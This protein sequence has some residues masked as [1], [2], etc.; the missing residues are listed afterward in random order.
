M[1]LATIKSGLQ[2]N[3]NRMTMSPDI[4]NRM[5]MSPDINNRMTMSP[6]IN[7]RMTMSPN[8]NNRMTMSPNINNRMTMSPNINNRMTMS[9]DI[10]QKYIHSAGPYS[11]SSIAGEVHED[12]RFGLLQVHENGSRGPASLESNRVEQHQISF[13]IPIHN[14]AKKYTHLH[15]L[16]NIEITNL[17]IAQI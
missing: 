8:I 3:N 17:N 6:N 15:R 9:P 2:E 14:K 4:N 11:E 1:S 5:T 12:V 13:T 16:R 7:N 10:N